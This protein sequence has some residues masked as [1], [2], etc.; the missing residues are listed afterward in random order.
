MDK[1]PP[2][3]KQRNQADQDSARHRHQAT[4]VALDGLGRS[5][6]GVPEEVGELLKKAVELNQV[7]VG[8]ITSKEDLRAGIE[9][10]RVVTEIIDKHMQGAT[11]DFHTRD[12]LTRALTLV[13]QIGHTRAQ[14][15]AFSEQQDLLSEL[16]GVL[17]QKM[18]FNEMGD[19]AAAQ[20]LGII[21]SQ[22]S[23][24]RDARS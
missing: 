4:L 10:A 11:L 23:I 22:E 14:I 3:P 12:Q 6:G 13:N 16:E 17:N 24:E 9:A 21:P 20:K 7:P 5:L 15:M 19:Y 2:T 18:L 8:G 1:S